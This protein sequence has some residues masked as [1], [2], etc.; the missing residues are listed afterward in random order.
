MKAGRYRGISEG[1]QA[2]CSQVTTF[3]ALVNLLFPGRAPCTCFLAVCASVNELRRCLL[4]NRHVTIQTLKQP[5]DLSSL[6]TSDTKPNSR[7]PS[8]KP[9]KTSSANHPN[10]IY[11]IFI[12]HSN[13]MITSELIS[14]HCWALKQNHHS[15][16]IKI[17]IL[18]TCLSPICNS[19]LSSSGK[20]FGKLI[21]YNLCKLPLSPFLYAEST[22]Q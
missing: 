21:S 4:K 19:M 7:H 9:S 13:L 12:A 18:N 1:Q 6:Q 22:T 2:G 5:D 15:V 10:L 8:L 14:T 17:K 11:H 3:K 16:Y 20:L